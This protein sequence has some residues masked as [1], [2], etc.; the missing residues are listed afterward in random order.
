MS[1][2]W[3]RVIKLRNIKEFNTYIIKSPDEDSL[4]HSVAMAYKKNF[5]ENRNKNSPFDRVEYVNQK[6][7]MIFEQQKI[8]PK[9]ASNLRI[10]NKALIE[11]LKINIFYIDTKTGLI[12]SDNDPVLQASLSNIVL[13][14]DGDHYDVCGLMDN[15]GYL[16]THFNASHNFII[17]LNANTRKL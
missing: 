1:N 5:I 6:K 17:Y 13:L 4:F 7:R 11:S 15:S 16:V 2:S 10:V 9:D 12:Y 3:L 8:N 14:I